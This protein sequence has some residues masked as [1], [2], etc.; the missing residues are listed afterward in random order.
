[1][2]TEINIRDVVF[3]NTAEML[4]HL[5]VGRC[6]TYTMIKAGTLTPTIKF[7]DGK[8][9]HWPEHEIL[10][11]KKAMLTGSSTEEVKAIVKQLTALRKTIALNAA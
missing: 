7:V 10:E 5:G 8:F 1:M 4:K 9:N 6:H 2:K 3:L 11:I